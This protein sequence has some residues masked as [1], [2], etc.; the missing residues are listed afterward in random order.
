[1]RETAPLLRSGMTGKPTKVEQ[2]NDSDLPSHEV[3]ATVGNIGRVDL[4]PGRGPRCT[5]SRLLG[6]NV[7]RHRPG[8]LVLGSY[9]GTSRKTYRKTRFRQRATVGAVLELAVFLLDWYKDYTGWNVSF[10]R[11][12]FYLFLICSAILAVV[13]RIAPHQHA[14]ESQELVWQNPWEVL[15]ALGFEGVGNNKFLSLLLLTVVAVYVIFR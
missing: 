2:Q 4:T 13:S 12:S 14:P 8:S 7:I 15:S 9:F 1:V 5:R 3:S 10:M 6:S 11:A